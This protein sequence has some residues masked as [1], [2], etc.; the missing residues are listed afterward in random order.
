MQQTAVCLLKAL[1]RN[2]RLGCLVEHELAEELCDLTK[3]ASPLDVLCTKL[4]QIS[5]D[6]RGLLK[7]LLR[8]FSQ[9]I[10]VVCM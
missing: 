6:Y 7:Q 8:L 2:G 1:F 4:E 9:V 10:C 3:S 5:G